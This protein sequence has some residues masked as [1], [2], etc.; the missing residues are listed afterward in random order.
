[1]DLKPIMGIVLGRRGGFFFH[2]FC[3]V[4]FGDHLQEDLAT[5]Q[6]GH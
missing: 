5:C 6:R 4:G 3:K 2:Q 1:M